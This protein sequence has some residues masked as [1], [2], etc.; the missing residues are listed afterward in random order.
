MGALLVFAVC[1]ILLPRLAAAQALPSQAD[2]PEARTAAGLEV[3]PAEEALRRY[4]PGNIM[5]EAQADAALA[6]TWRLQPLQERR[7]DA[8]RAV[9]YEKFL[10]E[11]CLSDARA[12]NYR[13]TQRIRQ[14]ELEARQFKR[15]AQAAA[16]DRR[17]AEKRAA[18]ASGASVREADAA[19][20]EAQREARRLEVERG[21]RQFEAGAAERAVR[22]REA[23]KQAQ[24]R[25][26]ARAR[27]PAEE[28]ARAAQRAE[29]ARR[30]A[31]KVSE[32]LERAERRE[33]AAAEKAR[34]KAR[35]K[36]L[37]P[38]VK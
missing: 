24:A 33:R 34:N 27:A 2:L 36:A 21:A 6:E 15:S 12:A 4:P 7:Y 26:N 19:R 37:Q 17:R 23:E 30:Q 38:A 13:A 9:C 18:D 16:I 28:T 32:T 25:S 29:N 3:S 8:A 31:A 22:A 14:V 35:N 5:S 1:G 11:F 20:I 10:A